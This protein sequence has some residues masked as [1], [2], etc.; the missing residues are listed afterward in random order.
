MMTMLAMTAMLIGAM[1][2]L[3]FKV[4]ILVPAI[5]I[6]SAATLGIGMAHSNSLWSILLAMAL[7]ITAL[8]MGYFGGTIIRFIIVGARI[9]K[10]SPGIIAV[11]QRPAR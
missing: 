5:V 11:A 7:A 9:R 3:R 1:L 2:G 6:G 4:L 8:Q 10:D